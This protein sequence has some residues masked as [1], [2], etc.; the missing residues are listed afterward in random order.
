MIESQD[1]SDAV[2]QAYSDLDLSR[3]TLSSSDEEGT[4]GDDE[5]TEADPTID[6]LIE[7][8]ALAV[9]TLA[10]GATS[11]TKP[12]PASKGTTLEPPPT[13]EEMASAMVVINV[14]AV[15]DSDH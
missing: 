14:A 3:V 9:D 2:N 13:E 6:V 7:E 8:M 1:G 10:G 5:S 15:D 4:D 12:A 11:T